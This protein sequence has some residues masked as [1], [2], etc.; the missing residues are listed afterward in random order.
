M[1]TVKIEFNNVLYKVTEINGQLSVWAYIK[2]R[3]GYFNWLPVSQKVKPLLFCKVKMI[4]QSQ[5]VG[6]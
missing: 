2:T 6:A 1:Q 3:S 5:F 4:A